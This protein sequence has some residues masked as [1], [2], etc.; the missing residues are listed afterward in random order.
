MSARASDMTG[1]VDLRVRAAGLPL[2]LLLLPGCST[3]RE[4]MGNER[5][6]AKLEAVRFTGLTLNSLEIS[7]DA[8]VENPYQVDLPLVRLDL[9][10]SNQETSILQSSLDEA[11]S[12]PA[13][14][15][16]VFTVPAR[17]DFRGLLATLGQ[18]K[19]GGSVPYRADIGVSVDAPVLG[20]LRLP[21]RHEGEIG[22][23]VPPKIRVKDVRLVRLGL[24]EIKAEA[25]LEAE[26]LNEFPVELSAFDAAFRV[27]DRAL[28]RSRITSPFAL[29]SGGTASWTLPISVN[30]VEAGQVFVTLFRGDSLA[31]ELNGA[32]AVGTPFGRLDAPVNFTGSAPVR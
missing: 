16:R 19:P 22:V 15:S 31:Y 10:L 20:R 24:T 8:R 17:I 9:A 32:L 21:L 11:G 6:S 1:V 25:V 26:S 5:P 18:L 12:I 28:A 14:G 29:Q 2:M 30:P 23:P 4:L 13:S 3:L 7:F 27:R